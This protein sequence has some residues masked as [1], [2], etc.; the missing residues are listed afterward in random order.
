MRDTGAAVWVDKE[1]EGVAPGI[2]LKLWALL[3][4]EV[5]YCRSQPKVYKARS[6]LCGV[7]N[8]AFYIDW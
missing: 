2:T 8:L 4:V 5:E 7:Y 3:L 1:T 6:T